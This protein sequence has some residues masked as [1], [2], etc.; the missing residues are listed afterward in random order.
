MQQLVNPHIFTVLIQ[1]KVN[2][3]VQLLLLCCQRRHTVIDPRNQN[4]TPFVN[5]GACAGSHKHMI[6][7]LNCCKIRSVRPKITIIS[8]TCP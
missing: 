5:Q 7:T 8:F 1:V 6:K 3:L 4:L 2:L